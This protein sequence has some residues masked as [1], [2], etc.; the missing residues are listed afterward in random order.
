[1]AKFE[2][3]QLIGQIKHYEFMGKSGLAGSNQSYSP[4]FVTLCPAAEGK[5]GKGDNIHNG[6]IFHFREQEQVL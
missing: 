2:C 4:T 3:S 5:S 6:R 1:M